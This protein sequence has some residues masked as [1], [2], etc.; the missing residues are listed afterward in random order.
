MVVQAKT[1][2]R[3]GRRRLDRCASSSLRFVL[4]L[5]WPTRSLSTG[6]FV[7]AAA[8][9]R[10]CL[11]CLRPL[12][13][14]VWRPL[15]SVIGD[16][17]QGRLWSPTVRVKLHRASNRR[18]FSSFSCVSLFSRHSCSRPWHSRRPRPRSDLKKKEQP[19]AR[20]SEDLDTGGKA[21]SHVDNAVAAAPTY[22]DGG[23]RAWSTVGG[24]F[25]VLYSTFGIVNAFGVYEDTYIRACLAGSASELAWIGASTLLFSVLT[26]T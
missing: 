12:S 26:V 24:S 9:R 2:T 17:E 22:P 15:R 11:L 10:W 1:D 6:E 21:S 8:R 18:L 19:A 13:R 4:V 7:R 23:R 14:H 3:H 16:S 20:P 25:L 5:L